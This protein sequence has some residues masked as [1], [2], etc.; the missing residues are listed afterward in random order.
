MATIDRFVR[1][2][3]IMAGVVLVGGCAATSQSPSSVPASSL[4][5]ASVAASATP[6]PTRSSTPSSWV[7]PPSVTT[8]AT[9]LTPVGVMCDLVANPGTDTSRPVVV[10]K[11][12][13]NCAEALAVARDYLAAIQR[14]ETEGQGLFATIR[15]WSCVWPY[16]PGRSHVESYLQCTDPTGDNSVRIGN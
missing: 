13:V 15:G 16:V 7:D 10:L 3:A 1:A 14:G 4:Q 5:T 8:S 6:T 2:G 12:R 11:G 9:H